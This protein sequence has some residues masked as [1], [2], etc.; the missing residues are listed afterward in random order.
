M[1]VV[2]TSDLRRADAPGGDAFGGYPVVESVEDLDLS[3]GEGVTETLGHA[4][5]GA[6][7]T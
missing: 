1:S 4:L 3:R 5:P 2:D 6:G 7:F